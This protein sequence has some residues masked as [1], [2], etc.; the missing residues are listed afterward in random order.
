MAGKSNL[1]AIRCPGGPTRVV[2]NRAKAI[3][4]DTAKKEYRNSFRVRNA[5]WESDP[6]TVWPLVKPITQEE[7]DRDYKNFQ[8]ES[9]VTGM[10]RGVVEIG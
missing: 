4:E 3:D 2:V 7:F 6:D 1:W 9:V 5:E 8:H 10:P